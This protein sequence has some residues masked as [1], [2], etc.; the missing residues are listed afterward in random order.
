VDKIVSLKTIATRAAF[1]Q[2]QGNCPKRRLHEVG[3]Q[4]IYWVALDFIEFES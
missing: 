3:L 1:G 2:T 4:D